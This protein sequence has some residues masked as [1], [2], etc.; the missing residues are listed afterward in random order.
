MDNL[1]SQSTFRI[2][3]TGDEISVRRSWVPITTVGGRAFALVT[4]E[5]FT[6]GATLITAVMFV[7]T[8]PVDA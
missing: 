2:E 5:L 1:F 7:M 3:P 6:L 4:T 8:E